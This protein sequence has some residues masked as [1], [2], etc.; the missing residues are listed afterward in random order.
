M[1]KRGKTKS[2]YAT[3]HHHGFDLKDD[4]PLAYCKCGVAMT[5]PY[6]KTTMHYGSRMPSNNVR[7][8]RF[9]YPGVEND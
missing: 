8:V 9:I 2:K 3:N 1:F 6:Y 4:E 5:N 7:E